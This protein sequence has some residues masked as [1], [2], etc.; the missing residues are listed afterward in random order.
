MRFDFYVVNKN[1]AIEYDGIQHFEPISFGTN[2]SE[3]TK[4]EKLN[5]VRLHDN[6]KNDYCKNNGILLIRIPYTSTDIKYLL[7][8]YIF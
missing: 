1:I 6:I 7:A 4:L 3:T 5:A 8:P 2:K